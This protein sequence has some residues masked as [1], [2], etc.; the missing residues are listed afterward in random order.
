MGQQIPIQTVTDDGKIQTRSFKG[1]FRR[2]RILRPRMLGYAV[3]LLAMIGT[4]SWA[5]VSRPM[6]TLDV[7]KDRGLFRY[8]AKGQVE[9]SYTLKLLNK[10]NQSRSY[11]FRVS[12][13]NGAHP[14][15]KT[16]GPVGA[17]ERL[18]VPVSISVSPENLVNDVTSLNFH[19]L[20]ADDIAPTLMVKSKFTAQVR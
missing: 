4:F 15:T 2:L 16:I 9:N 12:G 10:S 7:E 5:L 19:L 6:Q 1:Y 11:E 8:N 20:P 3:I 13:L 18:E 14:S 17:G